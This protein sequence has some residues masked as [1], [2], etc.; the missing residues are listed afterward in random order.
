MQRKVHS[1]VTLL[2]EWIF[3]VISLVVAGI[4]IVL[5]VL[6]LRQE[7]ATCLTSGRDD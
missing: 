7:P 3:I 5:G 6:V 1:A 4:G 2:T